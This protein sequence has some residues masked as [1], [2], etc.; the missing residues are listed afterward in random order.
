MGFLLYMSKS[1]GQKS[2]YTNNR[3]MKLM[4]WNVLQY[5]A[6]KKSMTTNNTMK[7]SSFFSSSNKKG[8]RIK[9]VY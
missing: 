5:G 6:Y 4:Q 7:I 9:P 3:H 1:N 2:T 8:A